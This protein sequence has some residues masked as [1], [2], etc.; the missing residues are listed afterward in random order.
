[1][2]GFKLIALYYGMSDMGLVR[3]KRQFSREYLLRGWSYLREFECRDRD[4]VRVPEKTVAALRAR[5]RAIAHHTSGSVRAELEQ[6]ITAIDRDTRVAD[7]LGY[8]RN[9][10]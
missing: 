10:R 5:L 4:A 8:Q 3:S 1:M 6:L 9:G 7:L 2:L